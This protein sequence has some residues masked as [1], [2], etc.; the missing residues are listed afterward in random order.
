[1]VLVSGSLALVMTDGLLGCCGDTHGGETDVT[2]LLEA[3][4]VDLGVHPFASL[5]GQS[6]RSSSPTGDKED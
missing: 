1:M 2:D 5:P 4:T 3:E 6:V